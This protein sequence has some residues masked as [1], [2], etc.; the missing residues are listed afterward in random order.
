M[1]LIKYCSRWNYRPRAEALSAKI[2]QTILDTCEIEY[3]APGQFDVFRNGE[4]VA[5][6]DKLDRFVTINDIVK[7]R[8]KSSYLE[9]V[10]CRYTWDYLKVVDE[11][12][13]RRMS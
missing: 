5:S 3:G 8:Q 12:L 4:L 9:W 2:N 10:K 13:A 7:E 1:Y 11:A 6:K